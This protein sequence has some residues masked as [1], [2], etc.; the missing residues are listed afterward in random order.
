MAKIQTPQFKSKAE[1]DAWYAE[2]A[3]ALKDQ[4]YA[5]LDKFIVTVNELLGASGYSIK[6]LYFRERSKDG[7]TTTKAGIYKVGDKEIKWSGLG[8]RPVELKGKSNDDLKA[9]KLNVKV[10]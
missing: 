8:K 7:S 4:E 9:L 1:L 10:G 3:K 2:Q 5:E 6:D